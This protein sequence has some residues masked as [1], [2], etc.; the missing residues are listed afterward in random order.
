[1]IHYRF[2]RARLERLIAKESTTWMADAQAKTQAFRN[3]KRYK[4]KKGSWGS[5]KRAYM[6]LQYGKCAYCERKVGDDKES[7]VEHDVEHFRP[8]GK[9]RSWPTEKRAAQLAYPFTTGEAAD[10][11]YY[12]LAYNISN[13]AVTCKKCN[14]TYKSNYFPIAGAARC[15][16]DDAPTALAQEQP[17]L[18][19]PL[20]DLDAR[21]EDL[22]TFQGTIAVPVADAGHDHDRARVTID[23][24]KL[25]VGRDELLRERAVLLK[26]LYW[27]LDDL[28]ETRNP[29][30]RA[31]ARQTVRMALSRKNPHTNCLR[32]FFMLYRT[33]QKTADQCYG[34]I[35]EYLQKKGL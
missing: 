19:Y 4:E 30:R 6:L 25:A 15:L 26:A 28:K 16:D 8:K 33:D 5:I 22:I 32:S 12:L 13:Y 3:L 2:S 10:N 34:A 1:M 27:A 35:Y 9:V 21:P 14:T 31:A 18:I 29:L 7:R 20:G 17:F 23:F 11:G 24:F